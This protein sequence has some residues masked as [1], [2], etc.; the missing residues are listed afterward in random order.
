MAIDCAYLLRL[1]LLPLRKELLI[2]G[3]LTPAFQQCQRRLYSERRF[4]PACLLSPTTLTAKDTYRAC[5][6]Q[7]PAAQ[8]EDM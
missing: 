6:G 5:T 8:I 4:R 1:L 7:R 2:H 3:P